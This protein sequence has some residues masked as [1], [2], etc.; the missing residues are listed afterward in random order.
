MTGLTRLNKIEDNQ[1]EILRLLQGLCSGVGATSTDDMEELLDEPINEEETFK[2]MDDRSKEQD[3]KQS[4]VSYDILFW[5]WIRTCD[6]FVNFMFTN[7]GLW[8]F[9]TIS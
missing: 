9:E 4:M 1:Q 7:W 2:N 5:R 6:N 3:Y 8:H